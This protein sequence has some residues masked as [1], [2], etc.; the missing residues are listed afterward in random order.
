[1][2]GSGLV[3]EGGKF[4]NRI[5]ENLKVLFRNFSKH[6]LSEYTAQCAYYTILALIPFLILVVTLIQYTGV[7][8]DTLYWVIQ[9]VIPS[10][11]AEAAI[12]IVQEVYSKSI[13]TISISAIF[14]IWSARKGFFA[15]TKGL[16]CI[17]ETKNNYVKL[18][19]KSIISTVSFVLLV[20][21]V[22][23]LSV[24]G[25]SITEFLQ[26]RFNIGSHVAN[27]VRVTQV[28]I[29]FVLFAVLIIIY[30][31]IPGHK[32]TIKHHAPGAL[33]AS[34]GLYLISFFFSTYFNIFKGFSV[35]YG[36]L[37]T[38]MLSLLWIYYCMYIILIGAEVNC[39]LIKKKTIQF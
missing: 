16:H 24:F 27:I 38:I 30:R 7:S 6:N 10:S 19:I 11:M 1:M 4:M 39:F 35:M 17:Y 23:V 22:L 26:N 34:S 13:G 9:S 2:L 18:Q 15:L 31:F 32:I 25:N 33:I 14:V 37:T 29:Y 3:D 20:I 12:G 5:V 8:Q 28:L 36:S 21:L